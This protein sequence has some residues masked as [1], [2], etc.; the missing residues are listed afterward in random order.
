MHG[1]PQTTPTTQRENDPRTYQIIGAALEVQH[2]LGAGFL[3]R[4]YACALERE[5]VRRDIP[6]EAEKELP[7]WFKGERLA[8]TYKPD[9][10]CY[11]EVVVELK[12]IVALGANEV[13]QVLNYLKLGGF[14]VGLLVNF[15][16]TE[17]EVRR[18]GF[19]PELR[20]GRWLR[21][22]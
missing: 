3:E 14:K 13:A 8:C 1:E 6:Y 5:F 22:V 20:R 12:A 4:V 7:V 10:L 19:T 16:A 2:E 18:L 15:G 21:T 17:L 11:G 9:F